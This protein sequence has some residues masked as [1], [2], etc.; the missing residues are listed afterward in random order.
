MLSEEQKNELLALGRA[1]ELRNDFSILR[2]N[3]A[4]RAPKNV[5]DLIAFLAFADAFGKSVV[6]KRPL[7][8]G[9]CQL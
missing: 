9:R 1:Q 7:D 5:D 3:T 2:K 8:A 4:S 6:R